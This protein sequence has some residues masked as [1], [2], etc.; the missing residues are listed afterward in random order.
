MLGKIFFSRYVKIK[1]FMVSSS[2]KHITEPN[3]V[4]GLSLQGSKQWAYRC[5]HK[6]QLGAAQK[7]NVQTYGHNV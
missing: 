7:R 5:S 1:W 6:F 4:I 3:Y 2:E